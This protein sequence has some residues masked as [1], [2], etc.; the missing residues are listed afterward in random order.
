MGDVQ[1]EIRQVVIDNKFRQQVL[2]GQ[3]ETAYADWLKRQRAEADIQMQQIAAA[4]P[5]V[6]RGD[7]VA[8][9]L[10]PD[11]T[12]QDQ[13]GNE[14]TLS[15][16]F[17]QP[18]LLYFWTTWCP[19]CQ[20]ELPVIEATYQEYKDQGF[21]VLAV[22]VQ[23][24]PAQVQTF[25]QE[26]GLTLPT[27]LDETGAVAKRYR[28]RGLPTSFFVNPQGAI[29]AVQVGAMSPQ[30]LEQFTTGA[31]TST[32]VPQQMRA[33]GQDDDHTDNEVHWHTRLRI[34]VD[35]REEKLFNLENQEFIDIHH[36]NL[37]LGE[38][39]A[40]YKINYAEDCILDTCQETER[41]GTLT[42]RINGEVTADFAGYILKDGDEV[43]MELQ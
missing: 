4:E 7:P 10:A 6:S 15:D 11:F 38:A 25:I 36:P 22:N 31:I 42:V 13:A 20:A 16:S 43:V 26:S 40:T 14:V 34:I 1:A 23:E 35:G 17:G 28:V 12:L 24:Q 41:R 2:A 39:L 27:V 30:V 29:T 32:Q 3:A 21:R 9:A 18:L 33:A 19:P 37:T 5:V 8:G